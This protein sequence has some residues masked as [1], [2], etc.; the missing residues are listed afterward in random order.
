MFSG[1][2]LTHIRRVHSEFEA[3]EETALHKCPHCPCA[4]KK[5]GSL[6]SHLSRF[7]KDEEGVEKT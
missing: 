5:I 6:K 1:N 4:F 2:M 3:E 7:H